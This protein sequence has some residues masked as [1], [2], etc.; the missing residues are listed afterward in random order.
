[1]SMIKIQIIHE[2]FILTLPYRYAAKGSRPPFH[3]CLNISAARPPFKNLYVL[4][5]TKWPRM[6][7]VCLHVLSN[8]MVKF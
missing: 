3:V 7:K 2:T 6:S 4:L 1:M 8:K 5:L